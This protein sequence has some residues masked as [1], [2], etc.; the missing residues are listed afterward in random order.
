MELE[1]VDRVAGDDGGECLIADAQTYLAKQAVDAHLFDETTQA[2][3]T[4]RAD[5]ATITSLCRVSEVRWHSAADASRPAAL[6][7]GYILP[8]C[9]LLAPCG[10]GASAPSVHNE[11]L[12]HDTRMA[13]FPVGAGA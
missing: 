1:L 9:A 11:F 4:D 12:R 5:P 6:L 7:V 13:Q 10:T 3:A 2:V 8:V